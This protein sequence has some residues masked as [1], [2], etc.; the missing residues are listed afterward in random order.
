MSFCS[1]VGAQVLFHGRVY[2]ETFPGSGKDFPFK[3]VYCFAGIDGPNCEPLQFATWEIDPVAWYSMTGPAGRYTMV[4]TRPGKFMRPIVLT[5][6]FTKPGDDLHRI[7]RP[8]FDYANFYDGDWDKKPASEYYQTFVATGASVTH[9]GIRPVHDGVDGD[10][11]GSQNIVVSIHKRGSGT[12][13]NWPQIGPSRIIRDVDCGGAKDYVYY[14]GWNSGEVPLTPGE[15]YAVHLKGEKPFQMFQQPN[16]DKRT[17]CYRIGADKTG[18]QGADIWM[19][20]GTDN[21][22]LLIPYN[23]CSNKEY[24][25]FA[26]GSTKWSQTYVA[27]GTSLAA[28]LLSAAVGTAHPPLSRTRLRVRVREGGP[29]GPV[30]GVE[31]IAVGCGNYTGDAS[32]GWFCAVYSPGEVPLKPG[33]TYAIEW[34]TMETPQSLHDY[35]NCKGVKSDLKPGFNPYKKVA[36]DEYSLGTSYK[37]GTVKQDFDLDMQVIEYKNTPKDWDKA[38]VQKNLIRNGDMS[39]GEVASKPGDS[40]QPAFWKSWSLGTATS[41]AYIVDDMD[42]PNRLL[43]V[44]GNPKDNSTVDGGFVQKVE[45]LDHLE[46]YRLSA[47]AR[48]TWQMSNNHSLYVGYDPTGQD[49]DP[50]A[51]S[52]VW[53]PVVGTHDVWIDFVSEPIRPEK[54]S[55]SVWLRGKSISPEQFAFEADFDD[56]QLCCVKSGVPDKP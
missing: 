43:R 13:D 35:V 15:I 3:A 16:D 17:D 33:K 7:V 49:T 18:W 29:N 27:Q 25:E 51:T 46:T 5:N 41:T 2:G 14:A 44:T 36:G 37:D 52:I 24:M 30:V 21:D 42:A 11:P 48:C 22:G 47:R 34:E 8:K 4:F 50:A 20:V 10:G 9:V 55:I 53:V 6:I 26:G 54:D 39:L 12:P 40:G 32:W 28:V 23:K 56:V 38:V 1:M 19:A 45:G 31:K